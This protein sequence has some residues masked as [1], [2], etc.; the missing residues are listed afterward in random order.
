LACENKTQVDKKM[1]EPVHF[2]KRCKNSKMLE[3]NIL[4]IVTEVVCVSF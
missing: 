1:C 3:M 2:K 4:T